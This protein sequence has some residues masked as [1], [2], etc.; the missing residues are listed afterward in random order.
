M[1]ARLLMHDGASSRRRATGPG[2]CASAAVTAAEW[3]T[4]GAATVAARALARDTATTLRIKCFSSLLDCSIYQIANI[5][6]LRGNR[7][8]RQNCNFNKINELAIKS[9]GR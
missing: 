2:R 8:D 5:L 9:T 6:I 3:P 4:I 7:F 1:D